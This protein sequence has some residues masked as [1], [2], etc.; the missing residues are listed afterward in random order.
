MMK[1][2]SPWFRRFYKEIKKMSPHFK[3]VKL[4]YGFYR[5]YWTGGGEPAYI[6]EVYKD[7]P[8]LGY[9]WEDDDVRLESQKYYEEYEDKVELTRKLKNYVEGYVDAIHTMQKRHF[10]LMNDREFRQEA[11]NAYRQVKVK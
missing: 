9:D 1:E 5:I 8:Y 4:K 10:Q 7:M 6:H 2:G 11:Q 3:F